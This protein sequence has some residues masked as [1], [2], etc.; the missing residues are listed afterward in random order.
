LIPK[1]AGPAVGA[2]RDVP[3]AT[4]RTGEIP[5]EHHR[6]TALTKE[7]IPWRPV[8][9]TD[10][11]ASSRRDQSPSCS[12]RLLEALDEV[13]V[14]TKEARSRGE[15]IVVHDP[16]RDGIR[17]ARMR[18]AVDVVEHFAPPLV[19]AARAGRFESGPLKESEQRVDRR[20]PWAGTPPDRV[21]DA[22]RVAQV[23]ADEGLF[24]HGVD[25]RL[26]SVW[27]LSTLVP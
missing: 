21:A 27:P 15:V 10:D 6:Q 14:A 17:P 7:R 22:C 23:P 16:V 9:V 26:R 20:R 18:I 1:G 25:S 11:L 24:P 5:V 13:V 2:I 3:D 12:G 8:V 19:Y 4:P